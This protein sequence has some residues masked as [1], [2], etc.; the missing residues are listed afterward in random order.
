MS[1]LDLVGHKYGKLTVVEE[2]A[3][4]GRKRRFLCKC[5][6]GNEIEVAMHSLRTGG[7]K[8]CGCLR[9]R[10]PSNLVDMID[11]R[12]GKLKV[13]S[14]AGTNK[15]GLAL[16]MCECDCGNTKEY[17]GDLLR[18]GAITSCGCSGKERID[19]ATKK[20][21][22][23]MSI[24]GV[25]VPLLKRKV[26]SDSNSKIKG[27]HRRVRNG[28]IT[29]EPSITVKGQRIYLGIYDNETDAIKAR[30]QAEKKYHQPYIDQLKD[31]QEENN[32]ERNK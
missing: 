5:D 31:K 13:I 19:L 10:P 1:K 12:Y 9:N 32:E 20:L 29:Y 8:S 4:R 18:R 26:R 11:K 6:C 3:K 23:D 30:K 24:D 16:W 27:V 17:R 22:E 28:K 21:R 7:T 25:H 2:V 14:R 15:D